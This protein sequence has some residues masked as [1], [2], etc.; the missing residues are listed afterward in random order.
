[1]RAGSLDGGAGT[2]TL[3]LQGTM[4]LLDVADFGAGSF[5]FEALHFLRG[6][7]EGN[8]GAN[9]I[10]LASFGDTGG[11]VSP[12][13]S[14]YGMGGDDVLTTSHGGGSYD[15]YGGSGD[16][17]LTGQNN[18]NE[19]LYG[20]K[21]DDRLFGGGGRDFLY[22]GAGQDV[23]VGGSGIN[24]LMGGEGR[25]RFVSHQGLDTFAYN[26]ASESTGR[27]CDTIRGFDAVSDTFQ[28]D[29]LPSAFDPAITSGFLSWGTFDS[30][31]SA[32]VDAAHLGA[33]HAVLFTPDS[34][35]QSGPTFL[36]VD[37]NGVDGY[38]AGE[39]YVIRLKQTHFLADLSVDNFT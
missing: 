22:G 7:V 4:V 20:E 24:V 15:L 29:V 38:Q 2:D 30:D 21:G 1:M 33:G 8:D 32:A 10:D 11:S 9:T 34:G 25:D 28:M 37:A 36:I 5:G 6:A 27:G 31:L 12:S 26:A 13:H 19:Y 18:P 17:T 3:E 39:D 16:D 14:V 23:L 35:N